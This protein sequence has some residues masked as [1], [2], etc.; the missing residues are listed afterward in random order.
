MKSAVVLGSIFALVACGSG[1]RDAGTTEEGFSPP[2]PEAGFTRLVAPTTSDIGP[3][4][5]KTFCQYIFEPLDHDIDILEVSGYQSEFGHHAVAY[6]TT[7]GK[8]VGTSDTCGADETMSGGFLG[9]IGGEGT[10]GVVLPENVAFRLPRGSGILLNTHFINVGT[11][12]I[13]GDVVLDVKFVDVD[14]GRKIAS[15]LTNVTLAIDV[16]AASD[17][18]ADASCTLPRDFDFILYG[19][20]MHGNGTSVTSRVLRSNGSVEVIRDDPT[21]SYEMQFN[22]PLTEWTAT[23][24]LHVAAGDTLHTH[25]TWHNPTASPIGFPAEMCIGFG[26]FLGDGTTAPF[27]IGG[28]WSE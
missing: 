11:E 10:S 12:T 25:C 23:A 8:P 20:H 26:F 13:R 24:P 3:G 22:T 14:P 27:C 16:P 15:L 7:A 9:G 19:N 6:S 18:S 5:D 21:W 2:P 28:T 1:D 17:A 4:E